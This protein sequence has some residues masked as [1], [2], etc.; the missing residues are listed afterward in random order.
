MA[1]RQAR[2]HKLA[3]LEV[4]SADHVDVVGE[5]LFLAVDRPVPY[6]QLLAHQVLR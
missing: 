3:D 6:L 1:G 2:E 4:E 5:S